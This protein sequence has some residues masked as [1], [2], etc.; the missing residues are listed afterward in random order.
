MIT[1]EVGKKG[2]RRV[3]TVEGSVADVQESSDLLRATALSRQWLH[4]SVVGFF[5]GLQEDP[6]ELDDPEVWVPTDRDGELDLPRKITVMTNVLPR[7]P[8][9]GVPAWFLEGCKKLFPGLDLAVK[10]HPPST[11][12]EVD[13]VSLFE[14]HVNGLGHENIIAHWGFCD[15]CDDNDVLVSEPYALDLEG[16]TKFCALCNQ[17][18]WKFKIKGISGYYPG[19]TVRLEIRPQGQS[20]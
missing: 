11:L 16:L 6:P 12:S 2:I 13:A 3:L 15:D 20:R 8:L 17:L 10:D 5:S 19:A 14:S 4:N 1:I 18:G 7:T 9:E